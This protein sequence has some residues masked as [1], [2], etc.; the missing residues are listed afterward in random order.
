MAN[1]KKEQAFIL[2]KGD[3]NV[4][5][6]EAMDLINCSRATWYRYKAEYIKSQ[7]SQD[8]N[9][10]KDNWPDEP[11]LKPNKNNFFEPNPETKSQNIHEVSKKIETNKMLDL[12]QAR[13]RP[14]TFFDKLEIA[15]LISAADQW[16][17]TYYG[18]KKREKVKKGGEIERK[19]IRLIKLKNKLEGLL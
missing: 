18:P 12:S 9:E 7:K 19:A 2:L 17:R 8:K 3:P 10:T 1:T 16:L 15:D 13:L 11:K 5:D 4:K 6:T 14:T